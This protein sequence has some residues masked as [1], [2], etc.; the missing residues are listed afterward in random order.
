MFILHAVVTYHVTREGCGSGYVATFRYL[1]D[2]DGPELRQFP[3]IE[4]PCNSYEHA[5]AVVK[6]FNNG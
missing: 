1:R 4:I 6:T 2:G 5:Q 3:H